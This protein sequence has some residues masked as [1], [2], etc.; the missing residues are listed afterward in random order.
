[1]N[2]CDKCNRPYCYDCPY[3]EPEKTLAE[4]FA[5]NLEIS[6]DY[7]VEMLEY[8]DVDCVIKEF[9]EIYWRKNKAYALR[10]IQKI[11]GEKYNETHNELGKR[12][13]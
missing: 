12:K 8:E 4:R 9:L 3:V 5:D 10:E 11:L 1:M 6:C 2:E 7:A 13:L